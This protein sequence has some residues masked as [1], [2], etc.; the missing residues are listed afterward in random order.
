MLQAP[1]RKRLR[2]VFDADTDTDDDELLQATLVVE[3]EQAALEKDVHDMAEV[4]V[5]LTGRHPSLLLNHVS[6]NPCAGVLLSIVAA[7]DEGVKDCRV[8]RGCVSVARDCLYVELE[9]AR[10]DVVSFDITLAGLGRGGTKES[11][12]DQYNRAATDRE[13]SIFDSRIPWVRRDIDAMQQ[14]ER[15]RDQAW[16]AASCCRLESARLAAAARGLRGV[17]AESLALRQKTMDGRAAEQSSMER[18]AVAALLAPSS[19]PGGRSVLD[20]GKA[21]LE[22]EKTWLGSKHW[23][24]KIVLHVRPI[25][26]AKESAVA[27]RDGATAKADVVERL[28]AQIDL[29]IAQFQDVRVKANRA[30]ALIIRNAS[31]VPAAAEVTSLEN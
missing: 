28:C 2:A 21:A 13:V 15:T 6:G 3:A 18:R 17:V 26:A 24:M 14:L 5:D 22:E 8:G 10:A 4:G 27:R 31:V 20:Q 30:R 12:S 1:P 25:L 9:E 16:E 7:C 23:A 11:L 29:L 19:A